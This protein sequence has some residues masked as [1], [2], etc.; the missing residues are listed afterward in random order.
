MTVVTFTFSFSEVNWLL[1][2]VESADIGYIALSD[3]APV[4]MAMQPLRPNDRSFSWRMN[5]ALLMD[6]KFVKY[7]SDQTDLF[8]ETNDKKEA[9]QELCGILTRLI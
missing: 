3:H 5:T 7:L 8:L 4:V 1:H 9:D 2:L 6:D